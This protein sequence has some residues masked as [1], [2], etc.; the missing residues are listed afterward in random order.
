M[1]DNS[2]IIL[3]IEDDAGLSE[4]LVER[5][6]GIGYKTM[7]MSSAHDAID[8][9]TENKPFLMT[10]DYN[11]PDLN[12]EEF[13]H[14][15]RKRKLHVPHFIVS[16]GQG[17]ESVAVEMMKL[18]AKDYIIKDSNLLDLIILVI[19]KVA[20]E[21]EN[22][23]KLKQAEQALIESNQFNKQIIRSAQEGIIVYD[24]NLNY[25]VWNPF[26]EKLTGIPFYEVVGKKFL[27][28]F[29][30]L[31]DIGVNLILEKALQGTNIQE[32]DIFLNIPS[33]G[34]SGW[35]TETTAPLLSTS[36][37]IVGVITTVRNITERKLAEEK[38]KA[39][40]I[41]LKE[42]NADKDRFISILAHDL[43]S[44][45]NLILGYLDLLTEKVRE[46]DINTIENQINII[47]NTA[48]NTYK[49]LEDILLWART[50]SGKIPF[51]PKKLNFSDIYNNILD[52]L[53]LNADAKNITIKCS[54]S[55]DIYLFADSEMLKTTLRNLI[56]NAIKFT[57]NGGEII[58]NING[59]TDNITISVSDNG[60]GINPKVLTSLFDI[61]H[62]HTTEGTANEKGTGLGLLICKDFVEKHG[63]KIWVES[64]IGIGSTF[65][66]NIPKKT[67]KNNL[68]EE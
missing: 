34:K 65:Y 40:E 18:G 44:P 10:L 26:M 14:E 49:L 56:S 68:S 60:V 22:E 8:W 62:V 51:E 58:I 16:T 11:L 64:Q 5:I 57:N 55:S 59:D 46:Y 61:S 67:H 63:G 1:E 4:L 66:F 7:C 48:Q 50:Q 9:L 38:L 36:G 31:G 54:R 3:I 30:F 23:N 20:R 17:D 15:L 45:F 6:E 12:G 19:R 2:K 41:L 24:L 28:L 13:I 32:R 37:E 21:I 39:D 42:L 52:T 25:Q 53:K 47:F 35:I 29:P 27:E 43:K 33:T